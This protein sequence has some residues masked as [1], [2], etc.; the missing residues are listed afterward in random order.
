MRVA[1][2]ARHSVRQ[3]AEAGPPPPPP[4]L[5]GPK[6]HKKIWKQNCS[7]FVE[8]SIMAEREDGWTVVV[9]YSYMHVTG[10]GNRMPAHVGVC[11]AW[12]KSVSEHRMICRRRAAMSVSAFALTR[13]SC[14]SRPVPDSPKDTQPGKAHGRLEHEDIVEGAVDAR[15]N[16]VL[17]GVETHPRPSPFLHLFF[18][19]RAD[20][21]HLLGRSLLGPQI[22]ND[23]QPS[24]T[25]PKSRVAQPRTNSMPMKSPEPLTSPT[26]A[27]PNLRANR[28]SN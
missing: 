27:R 25:Q 11:F 2:V 16:R 8:I 5:L 13:S 4:L 28:H 19:L 22:C 7:L 14:A 23:H 9:Y 21:R 17:Q 15:Q 18:E 26:S 6:G 24:S 20:P 3:A 12:D 1:A 10:V